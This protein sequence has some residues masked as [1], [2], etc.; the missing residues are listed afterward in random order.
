VHPSLKNISVLVIDNEPAILDSMRA[1][2]TGWGCQVHTAI[3]L[4]AALDVLFSGDVQPDMVFADFHLDDGNG[5]DA[6]SAVRVRLGHN[7]PAALITADA[8]VDLA[9]DARLFGCLLLR[10]PVR[11]A[12]V[13]SL[14]NQFALQ[15]A[16]A[17]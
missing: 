1:L 4:K 12:Q 2:L 9:R 7:I 5:L 13:R 3:G 6:I 10:K 17:E 15:R 11:P 14:F 16:A 8:S